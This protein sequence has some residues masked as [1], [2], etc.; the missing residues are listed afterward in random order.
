MRLTKWCYTKPEEQ[1][2]V[3]ITI[4]TERRVCFDENRLVL[5]EANATKHLEHHACMFQGRQHGTSS[6]AFTEYHPKASGV[7]VDVKSN[8]VV[9]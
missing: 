7:V 4:Q 3:T 2:F 5:N 1:R 6:T 9:G 8:I